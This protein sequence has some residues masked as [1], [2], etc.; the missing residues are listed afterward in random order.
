MRIKRLVP[1]VV[2]APLRRWLFRR[3]DSV[4]QVGQ[5]RWVYGEAFNEKRSGYFVDIGA[6]DGIT[7][8]NTY[9][10]ERRYGWSGICV[11]ANP[12]LFAELARRRRA[13]CVNACLDASAGGV[14]F[15]LDGALGGIVAE[16]VDSQREAGAHGTVTMEAITLT[17]VLDAH[18]APELID[19]LS[20]DVE[21]AEDRVMDGLDLD[22][23]EF[24]CMTIE[25]PSDRLRQRLAGHGYE[26]IRE[27][28]GLDGLF[29]HRDFVGEYVQNLFAFHEKKA[30]RL[31]WR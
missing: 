27:V 6:Y 30:L 24:R 26:L 17:E 5:D 8:S 3:S 10:L 22:R 15:V 11:E 1:G 9:L 13:V 12:V 2:R 19:Y 29:V 25:R 4:S 18:G 20:L 14:E 28:P 7:I 31:R 23:Y 16:D 21:G